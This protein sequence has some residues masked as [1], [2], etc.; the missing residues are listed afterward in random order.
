MPRVLIS[1]AHES[2][3]HE[4]RVLDLA[5]SLR[6]RGVDAWIDRFEGVVPEG[7]PGWMRRQVEKADV[8]LLV[9]TPTYVERFEEPVGESRGVTWEGFLVRQL[10]YE[11]G[12][13]NHKVRCGWFEPTPL[14][15][16]LAQHKGFPLGDLDAVVRALRGQAEVDPAPL[17]VPEARSAGMGKDPDKA[18]Q[19]DLAYERRREARRAG[20]GVAELDREIVSLERSIRGERSVGPGATLGPYTLVAQIGEGG[21]A[22][23]WRAVESLEFGEEREVALKVLHSKWIEAPTYVEQFRRGAAFMASLDHDAIVPVLRLPAPGERF[24]SMALMRGG[25]LR[26]AVLS[27]R[28]GVRDAMRVALDAAR[29]L[30]V[31]HAR[32]RVH[33]DVKPHNVL[34]DAAGRGRMAD[35]DLVR[36]VDAETAQRTRA[37]GSICYLAPEIEQPPHRADARADVY[38]LTLVLTFCAAGR[39]LLMR[40]V[41]HPERFLSRLQLSDSLRS[42]LAKGL[43]EEPQ[44]RYATVGELSQAV[45][46]AWNIERGRKRAVSVPSL[47]LVTVGPGSFRMGSPEGVGHRDERPRHTVTITRDLRVSVT[48]VTQAQ[49]REIARGSG[50]NLGPSFFNGD[51]LPVENVSWLDAVRWCNVLSARERLAPAYR[52]DRSGAYVESVNLDAGYRLPTEAE[53]EYFAR[54]GTDGIRSFGEDEAR[55]NE[56]AWHQGNS[57]KRTHPVGQKLSN[58]W[59]L[60]DI[61]GNV[62]E[63][64]TDEWCRPYTPK[65]SIDPLSLPG[66][67]RARVI[68][69]GCW[70][71][72]A[73][74]CRSS[75]RQWFGADEFDDDLGF[76][77]VLPV[78]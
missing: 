58:Q 44:N 50:L 74:E 12:G 9:C 2:D 62:W 15:R 45:E 24:Y 21:F 51:D 4:A 64:C 36:V 73:D 5:Q 77:V 52:F 10:L 61:Y 35:F 59:G 23:V 72:G 22:T 68:R 48:P 55:L 63:W 17:G 25:N 37:V 29:G 38:G 40:D 69:G 32:G 66:T 13:H 42:A 67:E 11:A 33:G 18:G 71:S 3:A 65:G 47:E 41:G 53:W 43:E 31:A 54:A 7:W 1:Y 19:L 76:R 75:F 70:S 46:R 60:F 28:L 6:R 14:P 8:V 26:E 56:Y 16:D 78:P 34:L 30:A 49:W 27:R 57:D 20:E 39:D